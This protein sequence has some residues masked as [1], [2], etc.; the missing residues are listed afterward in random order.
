MQALQ[1]KLAATC[2]H[3]VCKN[4][5]CRFA[6]L[7][8]K[9][10]HKHASNRHCTC[11]LCTCSKCGGKRFE[12]RPTMRGIKMAPVKTFWYF[13]VED[14]LN[15]RLFGNA[16]FV[17]LRGTGRAHEGDIYS[18]P[19]AQRIDGATG[20]A[21]SDPNNSLYGIGGDWGEAYSFK[22]WSFGI[23]GLQ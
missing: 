14:S 22:A 8:P 19:L 9:D 12:E 20:G 10:Y 2:E 13:G 7:D 17:D 6:P 3:H 1:C 4:D 11:A 23:L 18:S 21:A 15:Q 16:A 5:C